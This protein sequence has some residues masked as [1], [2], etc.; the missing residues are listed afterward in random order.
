MSSLQGTLGGF[1][2]QIDK[3]VI[4]AFVLN[5][6]GDIH[7]AIHDSANGALHTPLDDNV[8]FSLHFALASDGPRAGS[9]PSPGRNRGGRE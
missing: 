5:V 3:Q 2:N 8:H 9:R 4:D 7:D 6:Y 1:K